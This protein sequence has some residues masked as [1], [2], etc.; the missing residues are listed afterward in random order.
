MNRVD[1]PKDDPLSGGEPGEAAGAGLEHALRLILWDSL[2]SEAMGTLTTGVFLAGLAVALDAS[3]FMIGVLAAI[4]FFVQLLQLPAVLL[5]ERWRG[6][7]R[8]SVLASGIGRVFLLAVAAAPFLPASAAIGFVAVALAVHQGFGAVSG[9]AW[10]S[11]MRDLVP[12]GRYG[13]FFGLRNFGTTS[14][15]LLLSLGAGIFVDRWKHQVPGPAAHAYSVLFLV[16]G[17]AG[18]FGVYLLARTPEPPMAAPAAEFRPFRLLA[19]PFRDAN[20]RRL[21][22]FLGAWNFAVN[23]AAPFL[24]VYM[25]RNLGFAMSTVVVLNVVSQL[26]NLAF[27]HVWGRLSDRFGSRPVLQ[28]T[29]PLFLLC[30]L[31]WSLTGLP[32]LTGLVVPVLVLLHILMGLSTAGVTLAS[33]NIA[34]KL[35]PAGRATAFLAANGVVTSVSASLASLLGGACADFFAARELSLTIRWRA[36]GNSVAFDALSF[37]SWTFFFALAAL[38]GLFSL[39]LLASV[40]E[41][42]ELKERI[43]IQH[44]LSETR[45]SFHSLSSAAGLQKLGRYPFALLRQRRGVAP[46]AAVSAEVE[47]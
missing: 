15:S 37:H 47:R 29:A 10:N 3:N 12:E 1:Q 40:E 41:H 11:W 7:R 38:V 22:A 27:L 33:G 4:P 35:S 20:F 8:I 5:V 28:V 46:A 13:R 6:R 44:L 25:L 30:L 2:A 9:C 14:L 34:M 31:A 26:A 42:G 19:E 39:R 43:A 45:R 16:G 24:A 36:P 23:L 21:I 32:W 17:L 18:L